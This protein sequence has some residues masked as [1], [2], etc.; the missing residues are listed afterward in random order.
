[1]ASYARTGIGALIEQA[2]VLSVVHLLRGPY[3]TLCGERRE[4]PEGSKRLLVFVAVNGGSVDRRHAAG[5]L[6][7]QGDET[8]ASG[9]LRS[10]LWRLRSAGI[11]LLDGD[12]FILALRSGT[13][14]DVDLLRAW[15]DR[16]AD[17]RM[18]TSELAVL[19]WRTEAF[20]LLPGWYDEWLIFER[21]RLRQRLLHAMETLSRRLVT[22]GRYADAVEAASAAVRTDPLRESAQRALVRAHLA[23]GSLGEAW[24]VYQEY[25]RLLARELGV[26]PGRGLAALVEPC[27][28][29]RV[30]R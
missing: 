20:N 27:R 13:A 26:E 4:V 30:R 14:V 8:R 11:D 21:E 6:W 22:A 9:N 10:A 17:P 18:P 25:R 15:A 3:V 16:V 23:E 12:K 7:P 24:R 29:A 19:E 5:A 1:M 28:P 2:G